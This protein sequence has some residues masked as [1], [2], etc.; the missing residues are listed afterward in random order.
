M[1]KIPKGAAIVD[2]SI[3][4]PETIER[5]IKADTNLD[6]G[7]QIILSQWFELNYYHAIREV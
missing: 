1:S 6:A 2:L 3:P 7:S 4:I 5:I